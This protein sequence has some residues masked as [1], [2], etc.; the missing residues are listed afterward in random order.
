MILH[1]LTAAHNVRGIRAKGLVK[2]VLPW[3]LDR[4]GDCTF[5]RPFQW[6]TTNPSFHQQWCLL[7]ALPFPRNAY[8]VTVAIPD[9]RRK[10]LHPWLELVRR[11]NPDSAEELNRTGGDVENWW[12]YYGPIPPNWIIEIA[13]NLGELQLG[14]TPPFQG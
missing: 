2:G 11:C 1:H 3:N 8:R 4:N 6:L 13:R 7:G 12:L 14:E 5:R 10:R 9:D